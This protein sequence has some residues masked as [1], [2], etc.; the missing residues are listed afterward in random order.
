MEQKMS[1][2]AFFQMCQAVI[3]KQSSQTNAVAGSY[4]KNCHG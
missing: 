4:R 3:A 1:R 2:Q